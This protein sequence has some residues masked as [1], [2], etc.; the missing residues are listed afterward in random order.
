MPDQLGLD[1]EC[2]G[3]TIIPEQTEKE[4]LPFVRPGWGRRSYSNCFLSALRRDFHERLTTALR[5]ERRPCISCNFCEEV[6]PAGIMPHLIHKYLYQGALE[7]TGQIG[8]HLCVRC[9]LCSYVC[10][11]K[12]DLRKQFIDAQEALQSESL[13][14]EVEV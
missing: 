4:V 7:E 11:S 14:E 10:P 8:L 6:C 3:L 2:D 12:I 5:G 9:G 1:T 13:P